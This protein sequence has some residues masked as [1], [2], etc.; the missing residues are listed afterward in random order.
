[1]ILLSIHPLE[2]LASWLKSWRGHYHAPLSN[3]QVD[4]SL[5]GFHW[6]ILHRVMGLVRLLLCT[7]VFISYHF[8]RG[9]WMMMMMMLGLDCVVSDLMRMAM[10]VLIMVSLNPFL[11]RLQVGAAATCCPFLLLTR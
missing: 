7:C 2:K 1:M 5:D 3:Q 6:E 10:M 9:D 11:G 8:R 4:A